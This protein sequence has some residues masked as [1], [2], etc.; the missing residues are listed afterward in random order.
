MCSRYPFVIVHQVMKIK[1]LFTADFHQILNKFTFRTHSWLISIQVRIR[2]S[3]SFLSYWPSSFNSISSGFSRQFSACVFAVGK[4]FLYL[5]CSSFVLQPDKICSL[6]MM[7]ISDSC[8]VV[9]RIT[10]YCSA[11]FERVIR[12]AAHILIAADKC[13]AWKLCKRSV[14][15]FSPTK[16]TAVSACHRLQ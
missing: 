16:L 3:K 12:A 5:G 1:T 4:K 15:R 13:Q 6:C 11:R 14:V 7:M 8:S 9:G 10:P 2:S